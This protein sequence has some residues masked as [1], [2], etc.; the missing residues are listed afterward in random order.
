MHDFLRS[1]LHYRGYHAF[2]ALSPLFSGVCRKEEK[3]RALNERRAALPEEPEGAGAGIT[4]LMLRMPD[5]S[6]VSRK[7][8]SSEKLQVVY[9]FMFVN[10]VDPAEHTVATVSTNRKHFTPRAVRCRDFHV[11]FLLRLPLTLFETLSPRP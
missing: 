2:Y 3:E 11:F 1:S 4:S 9:D 5:G 7:F 8:L 6:R 10:E